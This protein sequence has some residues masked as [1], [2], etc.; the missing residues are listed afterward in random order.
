M[1][2]QM[3]TTRQGLPPLAQTSEPPGLC[4]GVIR[5]GASAGRSCFVLALSA[6]R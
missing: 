4:V 3:V 5:N 1:R 2:E 6:R